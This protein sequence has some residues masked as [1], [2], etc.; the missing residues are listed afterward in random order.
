MEN[1]AKEYEMQA[2]E[3]ETKKRRKEHLITLKHMDN[4]TMVYDKQDDTPKR[5]SSLQAS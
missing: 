4:L 5:G 2:K 3:D 1:L